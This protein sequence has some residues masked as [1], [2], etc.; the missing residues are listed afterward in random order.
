[1]HR[2]DGLGLAVMSYGHE[3]GS[4]LGSVSWVVEWCL[5][6]GYSDN[7]ETVRSLVVANSGHEIPDLV[8]LFLASSP[9]LHL[10]LILKKQ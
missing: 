1:M 5:D 3:R 10:K 9:I 4:W 7:V 6:V 8:A 2:V